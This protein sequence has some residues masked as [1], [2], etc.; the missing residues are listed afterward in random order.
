LPQTESPQAAQTPNEEAITSTAAI[1]ALFLVS[2]INMLI[3][4]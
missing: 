4:Y 1:S 3:P 2:F